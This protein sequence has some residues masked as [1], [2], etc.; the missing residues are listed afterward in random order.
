MLYVLC[1]LA[2]LIEYSD[3]YFDNG[4]IKQ[5]DPI[6][7]TPTAVWL[8]FPNVCQHSYNTSLI[9]NGYFQG[10]QLYHFPFSLL[11]HR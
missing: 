2:L 3:K 4:M 7:P 6:E 9:I 11:F 5:D 1:N 10:K 8:E